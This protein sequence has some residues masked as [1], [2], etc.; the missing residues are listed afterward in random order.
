[1][2]VR[3][4][5]NCIRKFIRLEQS[6]GTSVSL[7]SPDFLIMKHSPR[8][9]AFLSCLLVAGLSDLS[10]GTAGAAQGWAWYEDPQ[11]GYRVEYP[12]YLFPQSDPADEGGT[13]TLTSPDGRAKLLFFAGPNRLQLDTKGVARELAKVDALVV[14][15]R[16]VADDWVVL[17]GYFDHDPAGLGD[18]IFYERVKV[19]PDRSAMAGFRLEYPA[20]KRP[21]I[22]HLIGRIGRSLTAPMHKGVAPG[23]SASPTD[24]PAELSPSFSDESVASSSSQQGGLE[25]DRLA[26][27]RGKYPSY[28]EVTDTFRRFDGVRVPCTSGSEDQ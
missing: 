17:S 5:P 24:P 20:D 3:E 26:W 10:V 2:C 27:C 22:D 19:S 15:Y 21:E 9:L 14:T 13:A 28:D 4:L 1:M 16:R 23:T 6:E 7:P 18:T 12:A 8:A 11:W 25:D